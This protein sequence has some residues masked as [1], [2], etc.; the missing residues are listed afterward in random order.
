[1]T[2]S[3]DKQKK[4][5][6]ALV[7]YSLSTGGLE[8][9][10]ANASFMFQE[11]GYD[12]DLHVL[13][14]AID[15]PFAGKL[16][17]YN[18]DKVSFF[19]KF[20]QYILLKKKLRTRNYDIII[21]H[22]YRIN[23]WSEIFW[24]KLIYKN[25][26]VLNYV[27]SS[28]VINYLTSDKRIVVKTIFGKNKLISVSK[29]IENIIQEK[30]QFLEV[31]T[32]YNTVSI[33]KLEEIDINIPLYIVAIARMDESNVK[34]VDV[35]L[36]CFAKSKLPENG[37][38]LMII[39]SGERLKEMQKLASELNIKEKVVFTGFLKNPYIYIKNA[40]F[41][42]LTSKNE[43]L[44]TVLIESLM[45]GTPVVSYNCQ[46]GPNEIII[47]EENG[48]LVENQN[49]NAFIEAMNRMISE[50]NLHKKLKSNAV[51]SVEK[52]YD[53]EIKKVWKNFLKI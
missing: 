11:M 15:Y 44:P 46:T 27:H 9:A 8:R 52:F 25:L 5:K 21:D 36:D 53:F 42:T 1:M 18:V 32:I 47:H 49:K 16:F 30:F 4:Y 17:Q 19:N 45:L 41:T 39:G 48:L 43:G 38:K 26:S 35:L 2:L 3:K 20:K 13:N 31:K 33:G 50:P 12:V 37:F 6:I 51:T 24:Q 34:Q 28:K 23:P 10:V 40:F 22:R 7:C 14:S 29:G